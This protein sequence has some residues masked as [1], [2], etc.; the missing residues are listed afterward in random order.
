MPTTCI[1]NSKRYDAFPLFLY[2]YSDK[3]TDVQKTLDVW[4]VGIANLPFN[5][6]RQHHNNHTFGLAPLFK[7]P[8]SN[9]GNKSNSDDQR[10]IKFQ[11]QQFCYATFLTYFEFHAKNGV[12]V[13][14]VNMDGVREYAVAFPRLLFIDGD[15]ESHWDLSGFRKCYYCAVPLNQLSSEDHVCCGGAEC[16][17][18]SSDKFQEI[19]QGALK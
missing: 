10:E 6:M 7:V 13:S 16:E 17:P 8:T 9:C 12:L 1:K 14:G 5:E 3:T 11:S 19:R 4:R 15:N 18:L 2:L